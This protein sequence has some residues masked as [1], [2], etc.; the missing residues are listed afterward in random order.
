[1]QRVGQNVDRRSRWKVVRAVDAQDVG[2]IARVHDESLGIALDFVGEEN[3][4]CL[5]IGR[6]WWDRGEAGP[7]DPLAVLLVDEPSEMRR[8]R[9][10]L[11]LL[12]QPTIETNE[13]HIVGEHDAGLAK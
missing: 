8:R 2:G 11:L 1:M 10:G 7:V 9:P 5:G 13:P 6:R 3:P 4:P 12:R